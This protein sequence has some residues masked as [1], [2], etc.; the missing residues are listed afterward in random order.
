MSSRTRKR[1]SRKLG[2]QFRKPRSRGRLRRIRLSE[3]NRLVFGEWPSPLPPD[4]IAQMAPK[5]GPDLSVEDLLRL[6]NAEDGRAPKERGTRD[7]RA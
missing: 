5:W 7:S 4:A 1:S 6:A 2:P 3:G